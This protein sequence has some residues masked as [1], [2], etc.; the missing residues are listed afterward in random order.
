V[1]CGRAEDDVEQPLALLRNNALLETA[2]TE[3]AA[4]HRVVLCATP[5]LD[6][7]GSDGDTRLL[8]LPVPSCPFLGGGAGRPILHSDL[9]ALDIARVVVADC[10]TTT[11]SV[12]DGVGIREAGEGR[13]AEQSVGRGAEWAD[14]PMI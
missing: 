13:L 8:K 6:K 5:V 2:A 14:V 10:V 11:G 3:G 4:R 12:E 1:R 7:L 9:R